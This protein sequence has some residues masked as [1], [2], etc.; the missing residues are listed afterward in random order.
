MRW[1]RQFR[2]FVSLGGKNVV[3]NLLFLLFFGCGG[4]FP[5]L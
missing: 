3:G 2:D 4:Y 1:G 5:D